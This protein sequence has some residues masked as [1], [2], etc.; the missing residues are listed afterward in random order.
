[1][2]FE[3][4]IAGI[5][6][7][8]DREIYPNM[9]NWQEVLARIAVTR[10]IKS[11]DQFKIFLAENS[12]VKSFGIMDEQA[13][14]DVDGLISDLKEQIRQKGKLEISIPMFGKFTFSEN[15]VAKLHQTIAE[16]SI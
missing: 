13:N 4:V 16:T 7:Y 15:D 5:L 6:R 2:Q 3:R 12:F 11:T 8:M 1:M 10:L 9:S 14:V